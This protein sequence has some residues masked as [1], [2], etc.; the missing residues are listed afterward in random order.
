MN[1]WT[2]WFEQKRFPPNART[3]DFR[4]FFARE[5]IQRRNQNIPKSYSSASMFKSRRLKGKFEHWFQLPK[6]ALRRFSAS[7]FYG[8]NSIYVFHGSHK[9]N[10]CACAAYASTQ[11]FVQNRTS[12]KTDKGQGIVEQ[13]RISGASWN[14]FGALWGHIDPIKAAKI[15]LVRG[16][17]WLQNNLRLEYRHA[18]PGVSCGCHH[19]GA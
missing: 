14:T 6:G 3:K 9:S 11:K 10:N 7:S 19:F 4:L 18:V 17:L 5:S 2:N 12:Y 1:K 8:L 13:E 16:D 15:L